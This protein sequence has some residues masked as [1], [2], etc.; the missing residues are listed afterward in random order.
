MSKLD[1][2]DDVVADCKRLEED[3]KVL[4]RLKADQITLS[5]EA[6]AALKDSGAV[7]LLAEGIR[8]PE[9]RKVLTEI[10]EL[11]VQKARNEAIEE[12]EK[13]LRKHVIVDVMES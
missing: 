6:N 7:S 10:L 9:F 4:C 11:R 3:V 13:F 5:D 1:D 8:T 2:F 12:C